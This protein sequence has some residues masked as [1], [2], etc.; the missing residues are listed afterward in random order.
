MSKHFEGTWKKQK[1]RTQG[2]YLVRYIHILDERKPMTGTEYRYG[3]TDVIRK[4][5]GLFV[6]AEGLP[7]SPITD[8]PS[9]VEWLKL[10]IKPE[11]E[12]DK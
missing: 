10:P 3:I 6:T 2:S 7:D 1:P 4:S 5:T 9:D 11:K 12:R 8:V